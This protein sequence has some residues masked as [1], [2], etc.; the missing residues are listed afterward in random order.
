MKKPK[1]P[2][3]LR[4]VALFI[5]HFT[6]CEYFYTQLLG[7]TIDW[8]PDDDNLYLTSGSDNLALHRAAPDFTANKPQRLDHIGFFLAHPQDVDEWHT[9]LSANHVSIKAPPKDH[10]DGTR[11]FYC[12]DP[13]G[14]IVQFIYYPKEKMYAS[15]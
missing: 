5:K 10:R 13:D 9:F 2:L 4:H 6:E 7:M 15:H 1:S 14:N 11:S 12:A 8:R 3:G